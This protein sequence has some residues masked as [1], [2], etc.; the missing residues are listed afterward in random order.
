MYGT[1]V[2]W[3]PAEGDDPE[4]WHIQVRTSVTYFLLSTV[5][6]IISSSFTYILFLWYGYTTTTST[7]TSTSSTY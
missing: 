4:I 5:C 3:L 7:S 6:Y 2:G 1:I